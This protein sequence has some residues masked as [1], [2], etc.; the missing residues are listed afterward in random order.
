MYPKQTVAFLICVLRG[1]SQR[2]QGQRHNA[3]RSVIK[4]YS[5]A[6]LKIGRKKGSWKKENQEQEDEL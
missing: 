2:F 5:A 1:T 3:D 4:R 6:V